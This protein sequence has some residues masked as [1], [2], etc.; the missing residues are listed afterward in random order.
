[1]ALIFSVIKI[2]RGWY[3]VPPPL[4]LE[5]VNHSVLNESTFY[6]IFYHSVPDDPAGGP[7]LRPQTPE[8]IIQCGPWLFKFFPQECI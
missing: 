6:L 4:V 2:L 5:R 3:I 7:V 8:S 1:M